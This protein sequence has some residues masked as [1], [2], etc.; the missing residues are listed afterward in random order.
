[1]REASVVDL[2]DRWAGDEAESGALE[3]AVTQGVGGIGIDAEG[4]EFRDE[5]VEDPAGDAEA[6]RAEVGLDPE[7]AGTLA[8]VAHRHAVAGEVRHPAFGEFGDGG[9]IFSSTRW[10]RIGPGRSRGCRFR[11]C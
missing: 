8:V 4:F 3:D 6:G 2:P 10:S 11:G 1:M 9:R 5:V 7:A